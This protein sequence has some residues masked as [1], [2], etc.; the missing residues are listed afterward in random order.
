MCT[1]TLYKYTSH[2]QTKYHI[3]LYFIQYFNMSI[4]DAQIE[5][6]MSGLKACF[7]DLLKIKVGNHLP[8]LIKNTY[9]RQ[10]IE[11]FLVEALHLIDAKEY[12]SLS[13]CTAKYSVNVNVD[14]DEEI[15][16]LQAKDIDLDEDTA[17][18]HIFILRKWKEAFECFKVAC[19][20]F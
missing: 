16:R 12:Y 17:K 20:D 8:Q 11:R 10:N 7:L 4:S 15:T 9:D 6:K 19:E 18:I 3:S 14:F 13:S 5:K 1:S 2:I